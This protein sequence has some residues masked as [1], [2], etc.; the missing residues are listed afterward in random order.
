M[1]SHFEDLS[2][3]VSVTVSRGPV[4]LCQESRR[5]WTRVPG[6]GYDGSPSFGV[7]RHVQSFGPSSSV[8]G[9]TSRV[10]KE[11]EGG[12]TVV[13]LES[14]RVSTVGLVRTR[15]RPTKGSLLPKRSFVL[16]ETRGSQYGRRV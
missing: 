12:V 16:M 15:L 4:E 7:D 3:D 10:T 11:K 5:M 6:R 13:I 8:S 2:S 14:S 9:G 1:D